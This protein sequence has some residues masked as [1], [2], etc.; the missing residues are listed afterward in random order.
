M[1]ADTIISFLVG[2][3]KFSIQREA[4]NNYPES[5]LTRMVSNTGMK[6]SIST[7]GS[8]IIDRNPVVFPFILDTYRKQRIIYPLIISKDD[9]NE[10]LDYFGLRP[11]QQ[12]INRG[13]NTVME[14]LLFW[15]LDGRKKCAEM[16]ND[17]MGIFNKK[18]AIHNIYMEIYQGYIGSSDKKSYFYLDSLLEKYTNILRRLARG[19]LENIYLCTMDCGQLNN[20]YI[21]TD[22]KTEDHIVLPNSLIVHVQNN[23]LTIV[24]VDHE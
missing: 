13:E 9:F 19:K 14:H 24:C 22:P 4:L 16:A 15:F 5:M 12:F 8:F 11:R 3:Q 1:E 18:D 2:G 23:K 10:E 7:D 21:L 17:K 6:K 20:I